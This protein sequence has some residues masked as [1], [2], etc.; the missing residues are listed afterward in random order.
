MKRIGD[1]QSTRAIGRSMMRFR[2]FRCVEFVEHVRA[3]AI[4][5]KRPV[6]SIKRRQGDTGCIHERVQNV[7]RDNRPEQRLGFRK[8]GEFANRIGEG[9]NSLRQQDEQPKEDRPPQSRERANHGA[10]DTQFASIEAAHFDMQGSFAERLSEMA[11]ADDQIREK[12]KNPRPLK[13]SDERAGNEAVD[14]DRCAAHP[15]AGVFDIFRS[16]G[17]ERG[18]ELF[19]AR[20]P[21]DGIFRQ[22]TI[23]DNGKPRGNIGANF[24]HRRRRVAQMFGDD[25]ERSFTFEGR[26]SRNEVKKRA[27]E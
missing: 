18:D 16:S 13:Q 2:H 22:Q 14:D 4:I 3:G 6:A 10:S 19:V 8:L 20:I 25:V 11:V 12:H 24:E 23:E 5:V 21:F 15:K 27:P 1:T 26:F 9:R 17:F 7:R